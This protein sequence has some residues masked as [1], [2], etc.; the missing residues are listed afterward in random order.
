MRV[1]SIGGR[2]VGAGDAPLVVAELSC[3]H[4][5]DIRLAEDT[6]RAAADAGADGVK[7]QTYTPDTMT[8]DSDAE[9]FV[10]G[11]GTIWDGQRLYDLYQEAYTPWDWHGPLMD[12]AKS[13][14]MLCFSTPFDPSA[15]DFLER[16]DVPAYK[17][18]SFEITDV[19][20][21]EHVASKGKPV[22]MSTGIAELADIEE[23]LA[24]CQRGGNDDVVLL[25]CTSAYPATEA[26]MNLRTIPDMAKRFG[27]PVG[28]SDHTTGSAAAVAATA[29][30]AVMIEKHLIL[31]RSLGGPD[32][33]FSME[34]AEFAAMAA[35]VRAAHAS[36]GEPTYELTERQRA[37]R[38]FSRSLFVA[39]DVAAGEVFTERNVRSVRP[40]LGMHPRHL[41]EVLG[42]RAARDLKKGEPLAA[43]MIEGPARHA[44]REPR[45]P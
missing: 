12:L 43:E 30:G 24:A 44:R 14:G 9:Q 3:N 4:L 36:L 18:A 31:D 40:G 26:E 35:D 6:I 38:A 32:A 5:Q 39:E 17:I 22:V 19:G 11:Q 34:P 15:A 27:V 23:A 16:L 37:S 41:P 13:L 8:L 45:D 42:K 2:A 28:L 1:V 21:I 20:L 25:K 7:L 33:P 10:I 29:L